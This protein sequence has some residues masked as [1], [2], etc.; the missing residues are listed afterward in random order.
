MREYDPT[1]CR[2]IQADSLGLIDGASVYGYALQNPGRY[3]DPTGEAA[4]LAPVIWGGIRWAIGAA[5]RRWGTG[6]AGGVIGGIGAGVPSV[7]D[8][9]GE[10]AKDDITNDDPAM[11]VPEDGCDAGL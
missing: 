6:V 4:F 7:P 10:D 2:Y 1:T 3:V 9:G 5:I 8:T 11:C